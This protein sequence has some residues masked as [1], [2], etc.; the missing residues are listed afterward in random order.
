MYWNEKQYNVSTYNRDAFKNA[1][2]EPIKFLLHYPRKK[3]TGYVHHKGS[4]P[5]RYHLMV[6]SHT[7]ISKYCRKY[8]ST[9]SNI[10]TAF[11]D[12]LDSSL[13]TRIRQFKSSYTMLAS[14]IE[15]CSSLMDPSNNCTPPNILIIECSFSF[16]CGCE[17]PEELHFNIIPNTI[18]YNYF[19]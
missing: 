16:P 2:I 1:V 10:V 6:L 15:C 11:V 12:I 4:V 17:I 3:L 8:L 5:L 19:W 7:A 18:E 13:Q 14:I 9:P